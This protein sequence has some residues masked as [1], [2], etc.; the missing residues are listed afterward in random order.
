MRGFFH[1]DHMLHESMLSIFMGWILDAWGSFFHISNVLLLISLTPTGKRSGFGR[2]EIMIFSFRAESLIFSIKNLDELKGLIRM[3]T[4]WSLV[5]T[6]HLWLHWQH[7]P[8]QNECRSQHVWSASD[9]K[10][11][12]RDML[13]WGCHRELLGKIAK[14]QAREVMTATKRPLLQRWL[15]LY[16]L[17][18]AESCHNTLLLRALRN[19]IC[20][21]KK[22]IATSEFS[23]IDWPRPVCIGVSSKLY[24][25]MTREKKAMLNG[26]FEIMKDPFYSAPMLIGWSF[27]K[28]A[29]L[30]TK[31]A[32]SGLV[33]LRC[34]KAPNIL[35]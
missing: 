12:S 3:S 27:M 2:T 10:D 4:S 28:W 30:F 17:F 31:K 18:S 24:R 19:D 16:T 5:L 23:I 21:K 22:T 34:C 7:C 1:M 11:W 9:G 35:Q 15:H 8:A 20:T 14:V 29:T 33:K 26:R 32:I 6:E 25:R 13:Y